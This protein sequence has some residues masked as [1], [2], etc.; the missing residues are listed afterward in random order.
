MR[1]SRHLL[2]SAASVAVLAGTALGVT[3]LPAQASLRR[4][5]AT[6]TQFPLWR[7]GNYSALCNPYESGGR[8]TTNA[9][10]V[11]A[12]LTSGASGCWATA[13][14]GGV[15]SYGNAVYYGSMGGRHLDAPVVGMAA[16]ADD[17]GYWLVAA[18]GGVFSFGDAHFDGSMGG[19]HL[20]APV[21]GMAPDPVTGG[22]WLVAADGGV[23]AFDAPFFGSMGG[24]HL[25]A[26]V[27]GIAATPTGGGYW[28]VAADGGVFTF[29]N[30][31]FHGSMG[32]KPLD[33][34][35]VGMALDHATGGYWLTAEDGGVFSFDAP[36]DGSTGGRGTLPVPVAGI[37][38]T[39]RGTRYFQLLS[40][41]AVE[42]GV[43]GRSG[44]DL[45]RR[46]WVNDSKL[47]CASQSLPL[48]QGAQYLLIGQR[49][50]RGTTSGDAT[51]SNELYQESTL[52][53]TGRTAAQ[54]AEWRHD[55]AALNAFFRS[56]ATGTC[57]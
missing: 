30:A 38:A 37:L 25:D 57:G 10:I 6:Y 49:E 46:A 24:R 47:D 40:D 5:T 31:T 12:V 16:T 51:A 19:T 53:A 17:G 4:P 27:V 41:P 28:L 35:V 9:P 1:V 50:D 15:F 11:A 43:A 22:Y 29:G 36:Y 52:P 39:S 18:D 26:P 7:A 23:F 20:A 3:A 8:A 44:Y 42:P 45:A 56:D 13:S 48:F 14:D 34:P 21:V 2:A 55:T 33:A 54:E 32:G